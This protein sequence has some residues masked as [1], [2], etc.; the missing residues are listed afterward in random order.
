MDLF[1]TYGFQVG[2]EWC[3]HPTDPKVDFS[4]QTEDHS[5][6][7]TSKLSGVAIFFSRMETGPFETQST[8][9]M[10]LLF[11]DLLQ[12]IFPLFDV[13][14]TVYGILGKRGNS[15]TKREKYV[16]QRSLAQKLPNVPMGIDQRGKQRVKPAEQRR[17]LT[18]AKAALPS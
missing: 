16:A 10:H 2:K 9:N 14:H 13:V 17:T 15:W 6:F 8:S 12:Q 1:G 7:H 5:L 11:L 4:I 3:V 18:S